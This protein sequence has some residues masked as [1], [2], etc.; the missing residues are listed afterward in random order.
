MEAACVVCHGPLGFWFTR[1]GRDVF[2]CPRCSHIQVPAGVA[3]DERGVSIYEAER[4]V[5]EIEGNEEYYLDEGTDSAA[6]G[7]L[8][9]TTRFCARPGATLLDV[10]ASFGHF[11]AAAARQYDAYG[12]ELNAPAVKWSIDR[13]NVRSRVASVYDLPPDLPETFDAITAWDVIEH[14]E[15]P[16]GGLEACWSRLSEGGWLFLS[17]PDAGSWVAKALG[18]RWY[19]QDPVQHINLFSRKNLE[20]ILRECGFMPKGHTYFGRSYR[21]RYIANRLSYLTRGGWSAGMFRALARMPETMARAHVT[22]KMWDVVGIA[23]ARE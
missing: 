6:Q 1:Q 11:L 16:R 20:Q 9:F 10:G 23:A 22:L 18:P 12:I 21:L 17:T 13:F 14:L 19:Y 5:F 2:R 7:K 3:A 15:D 4:S 8:A